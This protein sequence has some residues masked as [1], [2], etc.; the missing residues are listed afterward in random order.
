MNR[1]LERLLQE[2]RR[3]NRM[4]DN[5]RNAAGQNELKALKRLRLKLKDRI[6]HQLQRT[7][8]LITP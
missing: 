5:C 1:H 2:H 3:L 6:A 7:V 8:G 4:I